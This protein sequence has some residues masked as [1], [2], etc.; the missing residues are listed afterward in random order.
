MNV[1]S[2]GNS[3]SEDATRYLRDVAKHA[4]VNLTTV[5]ICIG[6]CSLYRHFQN[7]KND[8]KAYTLQY[9]GTITGF[10]VSL[11]EALLNRE[12]DI[13]TLQQVS[14]QSPRFTTFQPYLNE[15]AAY[16]RE[17]CPKAKIVLQQTWAYEK[18]SKRLVEEMKYSAPDEMLNDIK[19][20]YTRAASEINAAGIIPSGEMFLS[21]LNN[22]IESVHRDTFHAS[23]GLG[24]YALALLWL[25]MLTG[26]EVTGNTF[27]DFDKPVTDE[28]KAIAQRVVDSFKPLF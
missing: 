10:S 27:S 8:A 12:W 24:R 20:S 6:G 13:I 1:L 3:F 2:I 11:K 9:N 23:L 25:R 18:D 7:I 22:G 26:K 28:E 4:G 5:N 14:N 17:L 16:C 15:L 21:L 19:A